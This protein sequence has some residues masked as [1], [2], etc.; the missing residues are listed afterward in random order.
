[1]DRT[2]GLTWQE[3]IAP[4]PEPGRC[5][6]CGARRQSVDGKIIHAHLG[7]ED[8][9]ERY[10]H[11]VLFDDE[12]TRVIGMWVPFAVMSDLE[13]LPVGWSYKVDASDKG[14]DMLPLPDP[15]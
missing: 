2:T 7:T 1:M 8:C 5:M 4:M 3:H 9:P 10:E 15:H 14:P 11:V 6:K 13:L 12:G